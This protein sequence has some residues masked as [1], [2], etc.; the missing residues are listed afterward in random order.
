M[1][2]MSGFHQTT[3]TGL[4]DAPQVVAADQLSGATQPGRSWDGGRDHHTPVRLRT[5]RGAALR[6]RI[7]RPRR[8][9]SSSGMLFEA[10]HKI[11]VAFDTSLH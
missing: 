3:A 2:A 11:L 10:R 4:P 1:P 6:V 5:C 7:E 8:Y 9:A